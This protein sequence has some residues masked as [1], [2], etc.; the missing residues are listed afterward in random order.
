MRPE[1]HEQKILGFFFGGRGGQN[2]MQTPD[3][4]LCTY[5]ID[6]T[7]CSNAGQRMEPSLLHKFV[8]NHVISR[9]C[10]AIYFDWPDL[11]I[12]TL[13]GL[14]PST[15][16]QFLFDHWTDCL[17]FFFNTTE[18]TASGCFTLHSSSI[19]SAS[20]SSTYMISTHTQG[21]KREKN[22]CGMFP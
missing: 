14:A 2:N 15:L 17:F 12:L 1:A 16:C 3:M 21:K 11:P 8:Y 10:Q 19:L 5:L 4:I 18:Q 20:S 6:S 22:E 9:V 7:F 13:V